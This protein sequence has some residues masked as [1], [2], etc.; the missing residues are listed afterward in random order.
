MMEKATRTREL[1]LDV[2]RRADVTLSYTETEAAVIASHNLD[3]TKVMKCPWVVEAAAEAPPFGARSGVA[4][5]G[6]YN[7]PPNEEAVVYFVTEIMPE[8]RRRLPGVKFH[9]YGSNAPK[10][11][12]ALAED[13]IVIAGFVNDVAEVYNSC[14]VFVAPLRSGAGIKG[15]VI[16]AL[17]AG[18]P[19]VV[20]PLAAEGIGLS[21]GSE[22]LVAETAEDWVRH[23]VSLYED[24]ARWNEMSKRALTF[25]RRNF[26]FEEG[27]KRMRAALAIAGVY[28]N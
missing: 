17:A 24:E 5:L 27:V 26:S 18:A 6:S 16:G 21:A 9:I 2:M 12:N 13:D 11:L 4:F 1:E 25:V 14:R 8:L 7:H 10:S 20:S 19:S 15:K 23:I 22:A 28:T 3:D